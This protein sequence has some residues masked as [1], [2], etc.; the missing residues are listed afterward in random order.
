MGEIMK[1]PSKAT[2][3]DI[4]ALNK[5][6]ELFNTFNDKIKPFEG[7]SLNS[8]RTIKEIAKRFFRKILSCL[9]Y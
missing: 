1:D 5:I 8:G 3:E 7:I 4:K 6:H 2:D 9:P